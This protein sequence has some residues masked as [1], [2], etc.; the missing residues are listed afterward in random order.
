[1]VSTLYA[2]NSKTSSSA[3]GNS[4][5]QMDASVKFEE[6]QQVK[7]KQSNER[8][9][10]KIKRRKPIES[11]FANDVDGIHCSTIIE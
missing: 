4:N 5:T 9:L 7:R 6:E 1:M 3:L 10:K 2:N 11:T 8:S